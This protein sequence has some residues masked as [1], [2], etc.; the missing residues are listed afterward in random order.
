LLWYGYIYYVLFFVLLSI[1]FVSSYSLSVNTSFNRLYLFGT[2]STLAL[3]VFVILSF[4]SL[5][6]LYYL[7]DNFTYFQY[8]GTSI[9][10][11]SVLITWKSSTFLL[12]QS[13]LAITP[14]DVYYFPFG[15]IF[16]LIT[17]LSILFC[18]SYNTNEL[19]AFLLYCIIILSAGYSMFFTS[20]LLIFFFAY[21]M[22]L[23]PS[24]FIL[25]NFAKTRKC[26][27][28]AYLMF[29]WTQF[30]ALFLIFAFLYLFQASGSHSFEIVNLTYFSTYELNFLFFCMLCG[31]G[32][33]LPIWPFYGWLP[34][35]HVEASTNFSIFLSGVLV[36]FAFFALVRCLLTIQ[37]EPTVY[38]I[39]PF[40]TIGVIDASL[41]L[42]YQI[43]LK[44]LVAY[45]TVVEMHWLTICVI[46]G[47]SA[48]MLASFCMLISHALLSTN[49]FLLVDAIGRRFKTRLITEI[50][51][52]NFLCPKLFMLS[53]VNLLIFLGF[54][55][56][57][58]FVAEILF[59]SFFFDLYP[60]LTL[61]FVVLLYLIAPTMFFRSWTNVL[62]GMSS[63]FLRSI[64]LD[65]TLKE[66]V[67]YGGLIV[68]MFWLGISWQVFI[69]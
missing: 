54:P 24:F 1:V 48:L 11:E 31:F 23:I 50:N 18:L 41:K 5:T 15:Y 42:F 55:G 22:L 36:K 16:V 28:A 29:F 20:S 62:F 66:L 17:V 68:L 2:F 53:L 30:G 44:K 60:L 8:L 21:E 3:A 19:S 49:S 52:I 32:V 63:Y 46:S 12:N 13:F 56:S 35:A 47:Q 40:L 25:Y 34:K 43:D 7:L 9:P 51:G 10:G 27:E 4:T 67:I 58:M 57:I 37:L 69:V 61:L 65:L 26:V 64:P 59:F 14:I 6:L 45:S 38:L 33:K 39:Y